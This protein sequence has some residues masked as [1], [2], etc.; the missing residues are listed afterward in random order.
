VRT[1][2]ALK[3]LAAVE[4]VE[5]SPQAQAMDFVSRLDLSKFADLQKTLENKVILSA[6][7]Y[8][9]TLNEAYTFAQNIKIVF[10][11]AIKTAEA[12]QTAFVVMA[13]SSK[14]KSTSSKKHN[15]TSV[16]VAKE[17]ESSTAAN[18]D[19]KNEKKKP[20][21]CHLCNDG[22]RYWARGPDCKFKK[23]QQPKSDGVNNGSRS[24]GSE[25]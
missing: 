10:Q 21:P 12:P 24:V 20:G 4:E 15:N 23:T 9:K 1:T 7:L 16:T 3:V 6:V 2:N 25:V 22:S 17:P 13:S 19:K 11:G 14:S 5:S 8:P 18:G